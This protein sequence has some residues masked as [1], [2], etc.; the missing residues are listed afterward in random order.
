MQYK[1]TRPSKLLNRKGELVQKGYATYPIL[2]YNPTD[3]AC[4]LRLKE[5]DYYLI[6]NNEYAVS[7]TVGYSVT[8]L[9][10]SISLTDIKNQKETTK[11]T[12]KVVPRKHF[13]MPES[14]QQGNILYHDKSLNLSILHQG[15]TRNIRFSMNNFIKNN[16]LKLSLQLSHEPKDSMVIAT[17]FIESKKMFYYN[18]KIN[19][20]RACGNAKYDNQNFTFSPDNSFAVLDWGRGVWPHH[21][22][23]YW[24][25]AQGM[26]CNDLFGFNLG[27]GF[28]D[29]Q[30][31][32]ENMLFFNGH[33]T[34]LEQVFFLISKNKKNEFDYQKPWKITSSDKRLELDFIPLLE[35]KVKLSI[36][37]LS[38]KQHRV[39]GTFHGTAIL[40]DGT[41]IFLRD[42]LG[43]IERY[44]NRW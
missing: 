10:I 7:L 26:I 37:L 6:Y 30:A 2:K 31:A 16:D 27:F 23:W 12:V 32:T 33:A 5:W 11:T 35:S 36:L 38:T 9:L 1:I 17:P 13:F 42:F 15:S 24:G 20:M 44:E 25:L 21:T 40:E 14:S 18:Q 8:V 19:G 4:K 22:T 29:T 28:G 39:F 3:V 34:K 41:I 43:Y